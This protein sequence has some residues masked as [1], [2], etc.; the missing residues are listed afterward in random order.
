MRSKK[1][2]RKKS[3]LSTSIKV[4][5]LA[6]LVALPG[7]PRLAA[8]LANQEGKRKGCRVDQLK[9]R[10]RDG[11]KLS[12]SVYV[13]EGEGPFPAIIMVH[14]WFFTRWQCH[15]YAPY[16][17][18]DGYIVVA[19]DCRGWGTSGDQVHCADPDCELAD[20]EDVIDWLTEKSGLPVN[21]ESLGIT[22]L[23]YGGGHSF[24]AAA[25]DPR[26]TAAAPRK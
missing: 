1:S 19:Y 26:I 11:T 18:Q 5:G 4:M 6:L 9:Q 3:L 23:S 17:A 13:P 20:V 12:T 10:A 8:W 24:L 7:L 15:L 22:G 2:K 21:K 25:P 14:S 16:F